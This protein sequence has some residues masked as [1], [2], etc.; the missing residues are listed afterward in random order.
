[1]LLWTILF[2][3]IRFVYV[4]CRVLLLTWRRLCR[5]VTCDVGRVQRCNR[6][7]IV[8]L[9]PAMAVVS[10]FL[11]LFSHNL[12]SVRGGCFCSLTTRR[13]VVLLSLRLSDSVLVVVHLTLADRRPHLVHQ[14][15]VS[16]PSTTVAR[17]RH[18][19]IISLT[20][21]LHPCAACVLDRV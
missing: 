7:A 9:S 4:L 18:D 12:T 1:M 3:V 2:A 5:H 20:R 21:V 16:R 10:V 15:P 6:R 13:C 19:H 8:L 14:M 11:F 17:L